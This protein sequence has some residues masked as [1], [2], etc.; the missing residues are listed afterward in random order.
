MRTGA[1]RPVDSSPKRNAVRAC[2]NSVTALRNTAVLPKP[3]GA[4]RTTC[5]L[6][7]LHREELAA[8]PPH[9]ETVKRHRAT[10]SR[11]MG[12][13][14]TPMRHPHDV[15]ALP[16]GTW[17]VIMRSRQLAASPPPARA[18]GDA[19]PSHRSQNPFNRQFPAEFLSAQTRPPKTC[20]TCETPL[21]QVSQG[22]AQVN[23]DEFRHRPSPR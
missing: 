20:E 8:Q 13:G 4:A 23:G 12:R 11:R 15:W 5:V 14:Q 19:R 18:K 1:F 9:R 2:T 21:S 16:I 6:G 7:G 10:Q 22:E 3:P 17:L